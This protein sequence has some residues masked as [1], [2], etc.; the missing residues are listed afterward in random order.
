MKLYYEK[1]SDSSHE[2]PRNIIELD[3]EEGYIRS[4]DQGK[5][6]VSV[7]GKTF[8]N[9]IVFVNFIVK[10]IYSVSLEKPYVPLSIPLGA[11]SKIDIIF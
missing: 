8:E 4:S 7:E 2:M 3:E 6:I 1:M 9:Q 11:E 5:A 10:Q